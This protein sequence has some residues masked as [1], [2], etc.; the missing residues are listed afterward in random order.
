MRAVEDTVQSPGYR[1]IEAEIQEM[2]QE[3]QA[4]SHD[5]LLKREFEDAYGFAREIEA[6]TEVLNI[7]PRLR[8]AKDEAVKSSTQEK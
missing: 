2:V 4:R 5:H 1:I 6:L 3:K 8:D 7:V